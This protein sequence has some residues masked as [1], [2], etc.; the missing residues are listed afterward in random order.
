[1]IE[2]LGKTFNVG[3]KK[4]VKHDLLCN[5][6]KKVIFGDYTLDLKRVQPHRGSSQI[7]T[8]IIVEDHQKTVNTYNLHLI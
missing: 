2:V 1:V 8:L 3:Y 4:V 6:K 7:K 5:A